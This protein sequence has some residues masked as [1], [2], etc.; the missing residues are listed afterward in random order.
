[1]NNECFLLFREPPP[2][3]IPADMKKNACRHYR[4]MQKY[5]GIAL[6]CFGCF[7]TSIFAALKA[8]GEIMIAFADVGILGVVLTVLRTFG[9]H[10]VRKKN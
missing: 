2:R 8:P 5:I 3:E 1:M 4:I 6:I 9:K 7:Y 10:R